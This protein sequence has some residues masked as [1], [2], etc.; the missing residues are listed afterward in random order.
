MFVCSAHLGCAFVENSFRNIFRSY[1][2]FSETFIRMFHHNITYIT[3]Y[4]AH[5]QKSYKK[6]Q[7][8]VANTL[9]DLFSRKKLT[10]KVDI[11]YAFEIL[12]VGFTN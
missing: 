8:S 7:L 9:V 3:I 6:K 11:Q 4:Y 2:F 1:K 10:E 12:F 5:M